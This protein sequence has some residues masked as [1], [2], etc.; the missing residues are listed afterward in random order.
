MVTVVHSL[1]SNRL[2]LQG[3]LQSNLEAVKVYKGVFHGVNV[4]LKNEGLRGLYRGVG[5]AVRIH[6]PEV[7]VTHTETISRRTVYLPDI[8][9]W[10][11]DWLLR[12]NS[13]EC[14]AGNLQRCKS[15]IPGY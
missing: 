4:I 2:Q 5:S 3:E 14:H 6:L 10:L 13:Q 8:I 12:A 11:P 7:L 9:K 1:K 15:A